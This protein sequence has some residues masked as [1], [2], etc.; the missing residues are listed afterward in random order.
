M[1]KI[2]IVED[3]PIVANIYRSRF[4]KEGFEVQIAQ[5]G[6]Q[7]FFQVSGFKP[8]AVLLDLMLPKMNGLDVLRKIRAQKEFEQVPV[9]V[10]TNAYVTSMI[11]DATAAGA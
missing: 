1:K 10:L 3:D 4:E 2:L 6:Q 5:D 7:G 11:S 9:Y 8:D